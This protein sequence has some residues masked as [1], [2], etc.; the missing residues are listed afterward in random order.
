MKEGIE[1]WL[2]SFDSFCMSTL[3]VGESIRQYYDLEETQDSTD[4]RSSMIRRPSP[5]I[6]VSK[7]F[8]GIS[9]DINAIIRPVIRDMLVTNCLR[10]L[11][12]MLALVPQ[13]QEKILER[14]KILFDAESYNSRIHKELSQGKDFS[15]SSVLKLRTKFEEANK[16]LAICQAT[17][18]DLLTLFDESVP[19]LVI[20]ELSVTMSCL[21]HFHASSASLLGNMSTNI[22]SAAVHLK[23][24]HLAQNL[25]VEKFP[26]NILI[27][28]KIKGIEIIPPEPRSYADNHSSPIID[29]INVQVEMPAVDGDSLPIDKEDAKP[30][31]LVTES[32]KMIKNELSSFFASTNGIN[33][34]KKGIRNYSRRSSVLDDASPAVEEDTI[35]TSIPNPVATHS[36]LVSGGYKGTITSEPQRTTMTRG[37]TSISPISYRPIPDDISG[38]NPSHHRRGSNADAAEVSN[39]SSPHHE[40]SLVDGRR[41]TSPNE[42]FSISEYSDESHESNI[43]LSPVNGDQSKFPV[44]LKPQK[45]PSISESHAA[46]AVSE[47]IVSS[48]AGTKERFSFRF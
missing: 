42:L 11:S 13:V 46:R 17:I 38:N 1:L 40:T 34:S 15:H 6:E 20:D 21:Q 33:D 45:R 41:L 27:T 26:S 8:N 28:E 32:V 35:V 47:S 19:S 31:C 39:G 48:S 10:P 22:P 5:Y 2:D 3:Y 36:L 4:N 29:P 16:S 7:A 30:T 12:S 37:S 18:Y 43:R 44:P 9:H 23:Q 25:S 14:R 24:L